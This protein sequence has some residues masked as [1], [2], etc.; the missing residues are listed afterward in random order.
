MSPRTGR[1]PKEITKDV[2]IGLRMTREMADRLQR[3][4]DTLNVPRIE[5]VERGIELVEAEIG[6]KTE[7][8]TEEDDLSPRTGRPTDDPKRHET[9]IRMSDE[10]VKQLE[11]CAKKTGLSKSDV[12]RQGIRKM[13]AELSQKEK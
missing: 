4:A 6:K 11:Y 8:A 7:R 2:K 10:D 1:P 5:I 9:R 12:I 13:Y 3:C